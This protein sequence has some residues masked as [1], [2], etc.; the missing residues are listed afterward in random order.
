MTTATTCL[1]A[2]NQ[3]KTVTPSEMSKDQFLSVFGDIYEHSAWIAE[4]AYT[5]GLSEQDNNINEL[6]RKMATILDK[7]HNEKKL[8]LINLH[9]DLAGR[10]AINGELTE[11]ST[12]EQAGAGIDQCSPE[13]MTKFQQL[14]SAYKEKFQFPFIMA[15]KGANRFL[16][17]DAFEVRI[18]HSP[19]VEFNTAIKEINKI[20]MFRLQEL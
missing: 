2:E 12:K 18:H 15:V 4:L 11:S 17:L 16:I 1:T 7:S 5:D 3:F 13:E 14:N 8:E 20:A 19:E 10:A 9:P 6:H